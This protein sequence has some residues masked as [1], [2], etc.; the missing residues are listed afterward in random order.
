VPGSA[1]GAVA[2]AAIVNSW[3][4]KG[5]PD[6]VHPSSPV[7]AWTPGCVPNGMS[8][9]LPPT[10]CSPAK[11]ALAATCASGST[12]S[13]QA[14]LPSD[15]VIERRRT[16]KHVEQGRW[17]VN[18]SLG[19][20]MALTTLMT[21]AGCSK[22]PP[23]DIAVLRTPDGQIELF[24]GLCEGDV[25]ERVFLAAPDGAVVEPSDT[26]YWSLVTTGASAATSSELGS[27]AEPP[28]WDV[29]VPFRDPPADRDLVLF[30]DTARYD[31]TIDLPAGSLDEGV[32]TTASGEPRSLDG[33]QREAT[34]ECPTASA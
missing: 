34:A 15:S 11:S 4:C 29:Q 25:A 10:Q 12:Q 16:R 14:L 27:D 24:L 18:R 20:V 3:S 2:V 5:T 17:R 7:D 6:A 1:Q 32:L 31:Y 30:V 9:R 23:G 19:V 33:F 21:L 28:G 22:E 8:M 26:R 13:K